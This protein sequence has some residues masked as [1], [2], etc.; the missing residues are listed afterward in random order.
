[1]AD[2]TGKPWMSIGE[3]DDPKA[4]IETFEAATA[5]TKGDPVYLSADDKVSPAT[6][7]Q[8][9][10]GIALKSVSQGDPC[11]VL[12]RGR[13]KVKVGG[14]VTRGKAVYGADSSKR[15]LQLTDQAVNEGGTATYTI[16]YNRKLGTALESASA[17][18]D[19]IFIYVE[20]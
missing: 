7:A 13:V 6:S 19:L 15:L 18:D 17:A 5:I 10:I 14:A 9:C 20:K 8:D 16:Y 12:I 2:N 3:T 4:L 11:P 1:M